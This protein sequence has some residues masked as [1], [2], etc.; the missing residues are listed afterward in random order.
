MLAESKERCSAVV[1]TLDAAA[2]KAREAAVTAS[3][4]E[5]RQRVLLRIYNS[6]LFHLPIC[7][8][9]GDILAFRVVRIANR[10]NREAP[11]SGDSRRIARRSI[12]SRI[13][14]IAI[15]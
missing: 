1:A 10:A 11:K 3:R 2:R 9:A 6:F 4:F 14:R 7:S 13:A 5:K 12:K 8:S 15:Q